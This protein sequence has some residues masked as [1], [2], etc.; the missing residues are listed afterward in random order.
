MPERTFTVEVHEV[1]TG[2][3]VRWGEIVAPTPVDAI[4]A[5]TQQPPPAEQASQRQQL[6][7]LG[8]DLLEIASF[9]GIPDTY[10]FTDQRIKRACDAMGMSLQQ[11]YEWCSHL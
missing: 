5:L 6:R 4:S 7:Q 2:R 9:G 1:G 3:V 11:A 10:F 8:Q